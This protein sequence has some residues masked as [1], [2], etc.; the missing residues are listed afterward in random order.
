MLAD[1]ALLTNS[2]S[3]LQL[4]GQQQSSANAGA[5][6][7]LPPVASSASISLNEAAQI[8][9]QQ[10]ALAE[11]QVATAQVAA[12]M[13]RTLTPSIASSSFGVV[14]IT[15]HQPLG[16]IPQITQAFA[17]QQMVHPSTLQQ[18]NAAMGAGGI[19]SIIAASP[20]ISAATVGNHHA[21]GGPLMATTTN[22]GSHYAHCSSINT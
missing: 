20:L 15:V 6:S 8:L 16:V 4:N 3:S 1:Q 17:N 11:Q 13:S 22:P 10:Q 2:L 18:Q 9:V 14:P 5:V 19:Q 12:L 21:V 7:A